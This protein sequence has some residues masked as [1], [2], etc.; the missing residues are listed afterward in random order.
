M[1]PLIKARLSNI[2]PPMSVNLSVQ[3]VRLWGF[4]TGRGA[5]LE[6]TPGM[7]GRGPQVSRV[8]ESAGSRR[9]M[10]WRCRYD[11]CK[12]PVVTRGEYMC[13]H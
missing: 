3:S 6:K 13:H 4:Q 12:G 1:G 5:A 10:T 11:N 9:V 8:E 7:D 2:P